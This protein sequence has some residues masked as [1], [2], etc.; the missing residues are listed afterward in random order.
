M[1]QLQEDE[2]KSRGFSRDFLLD[3]ELERGKVNYSTAAAAAAVSSD[4]WRSQ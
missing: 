3:L 4:L 1:Q 2:L